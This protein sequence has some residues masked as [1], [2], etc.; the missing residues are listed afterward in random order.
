MG[1]LPPEI[2]AT[3][4]RDS[5]EGHAFPAAAVAVGF[6]LN[7]F[8]GTFMVKK[9]ENFPCPLDYV[10][11]YIVRLSREGQLSRFLTILG[12]TRHVR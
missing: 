3:A 11:A 5:P 9:R 1:E 2:I 12:S 4:L 10:R 7:G 6:G 8:F